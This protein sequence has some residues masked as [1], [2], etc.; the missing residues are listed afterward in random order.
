MNR[1]LQL[2]H[3][4][5]ILLWI[6]G[7]GLESS[8]EFFPRELI[9]RLE[10]FYHVVVPIGDNTGLPSA[11]RKFSTRWIRSAAQTSLRWRLLS[12]TKE[13]QGC[14]T[15]D[16][17]FV[18]SSLNS[19]A[20]KSLW[21]HDIPTVFYLPDASNEGGGKRSF[22]ASI[23]YAGV[24]L[25]PSDE[26]RQKALAASGHV[27]AMRYAIQSPE[28]PESFSVVIN[29]LGE[30]IAAAKRRELSDRRAIARSD[31]FD[32][33][34][35]Y[36]W[37]GRDRK[38][39]IRNYT[40]AWNN[41]INLRKPRPGFHPG[42]YQEEKQVEAMD[43][44][45]HY[46]RS[47]MPEGRWSRSVI[48]ARRI[49]ARRRS[50]LK[51]A[52]QMHLFYPE[53]GLEFIRRI[54]SSRSRP[55][56]FISVPTEVALQEAQQHFRAVTDR[57]VVIRIV[58]NAGR[59]L[60]PLLSEFADDLQSYEVIGHVHS[61]KSLHQENRLRIER[62]NNF[63]FE[64]VIGGRKPMIDVVLERLEKDPELGLVFP[65]DPHVIGWMGNREIAM[66]LMHRMKLCGELPVRFIN[67]PIGTMFWAR[68]RALK[69]LFELKLDWPD[70]PKEP[71]PDDGTMLHAIERLL[72]VIAEKSGFKVAVTQVKGVFM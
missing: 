48:K 15:P 50:V 72:P 43:P 9:S 56:L 38:T 2:D 41:G 1:E 49:G 44:L 31:F 12:A 59:D 66:S 51:A 30:E 67:F 22:H 64:N 42:I 25:F 68:T 36:P 27:L 5:P 52:L 40:T 58:P 61:K 65:D 53:M 45:V 71:V 14:K 18:C 37:L 20:V 21:D 8:V 47:G 54:K 33:K 23:R 35:S 6:S 29:R 46:L 16:F 13:I 32:T 39:A 19:E 57:R 60:G 26:A 34:F 17:A 3:S 55:D 69:P 70:Y 63:L 10:R 11:F 4:K 28:E 24:L 7:E 62:W